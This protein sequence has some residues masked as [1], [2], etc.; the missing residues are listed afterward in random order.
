[1]G[2]NLYLFPLEVHRLSADSRYRPIIGEFADNL[3]RSFDNRH[4]PI[5]PVFS[6]AKYRNGLG[7][8]VTKN[9][10]LLVKLR[11]EC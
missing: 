11:Q 9:Y 4:R 8:V 6:G 1:M 2:T 5:I 10:K 3:Y 7:R